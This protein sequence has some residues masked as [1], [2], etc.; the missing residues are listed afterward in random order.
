MKSALRHA[1]AFAGTVTTAFAMALAARAAIH[2]VDY[3]A[4][5]VMKRRQ[6]A[7]GGQLTS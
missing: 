4:L 3:H 5:P 7:I 6:E 1:G 2:I